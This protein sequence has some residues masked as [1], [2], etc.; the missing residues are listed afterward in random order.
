[1]TPV[2][3]Q[4]NHFK[5]VVQ[6]R[7]RYR[8]IPTPI[9][10]DIQS[11]TPDSPRWRVARCPTRC[12]VCSSKES[13]PMERQ[14]PKCGSLFSL[15]ESNRYQRAGYPLGP[16]NAPSPQTQR[17]KKPLAGL[18]KHF[19]FSFLV[20]T[21]R[22]APFPFGKCREGVVANP[23]FSRSLLYVLGTFLLLLAF[24]NPSRAQ[25]IT[26]DGSLPTPTAVNQVGTTW[27][28]SGG[29]RPGGQNGTTLYHSFGNFSVPANNTAMFLNNPAAPTTNNILGRVTGG[30]VSSIMG[31]IDTT[32][33]FP[34]ASLFLMNTAGFIFGPNATLNVGGAFTA[35]N[36]NNIEMDDVNGTLFNAVPNAAADQL[37]VTASVEAFGFLGDA[38][39]GIVAGS[40]AAIEVQGLNTQGSKVTLVGRDAIAGAGGPKVEGVE[41]NGTINSQGGDVILASLDS[42]GKALPGSISFEDVSQQGQTTISANIETAGGKI[43][44]EGGQIIITGNLISDGGE[45]LI[46]EDALAGTQADISGAITTGGGNVSIAQEATTGIQT[47]LT[48]DVDTGGG[49]FV[50]AENA[51][52][53]GQTDIAST[54]MTSGGEVKIDENV[55]TGGEFTISGTATTVGG[56]VTIGNENT[57]VGQVTIKENGSIDTS[58]S[59]LPPLPPFP[60]PQPGSADGGKVVIRGEVL[61]IDENSEIKTEPRRGLPFAPSPGKGGP[62]DIRAGT[63][64]SM[65]DSEINSSALF[66]SD[67]GSVSIIGPTVKLEN[68]AINATAGNAPAGGSGSGGNVEIA[69]SAAATLSVKNSDIETG[70]IGG[71]TGNGGSVTLNGPKVVLEDGFIDAGS[72]SNTGRGGRVE[73]NVG[74][75]TL[76]NYVVRSSTAGG[77]QAGSFIVQ[78]EGGDGTLAKTVFIQADSVVRT[79]SNNTTAQ[80]GGGMIGVFA[81][82]VSLLSGGTLDARSVSGVAGQVHVTGAEGVTISGKSSTGVVSSTTVQRLFGGT[83]GTTSPAVTIDTQ[84]FT[85]SG[86]GRITLTNSGEGPGGN[87]ILQGAGGGGTLAEAVTVSGQDNL[88]NPS[89][90]FSTTDGM[91]PGGN[92]ILNAVQAT[93]ANGATVTASS[94]SANAGAGTAG[95]VTIETSGSIKVDQATVASEAVQGNGGDVN[96]LA[97]KD[98][99]VTK[100]ST[101]TAKSTNGR[102]GDINAEAGDSIRVFD[103]ELLTVS[104]TGNGGDIDL[105]AGNG[106]FVDPSLISTSVGAGIGGNITMDADNIVIQLSQILAQAQGGQGG[107]ITLTANVVLVDPF[108]TI[109]ASGGLGGLP[110]VVDIQAPI[111]NLNGVIAPLSEQ[112]INPASL[113]AQRCAAQKGGQFSSFVNGGRDGSPPAPGGFLPSPLVFSQHAGVKA[114][115]GKID[116][117]NFTIVRLGFVNFINPRGLEK[118]KLMAGI[119]LKFGCA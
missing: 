52:V 13:N 95:T 2:H 102:A 67:A 37:L 46:A 62:V 5:E 81:Q 114:G 108:S 77:L 29:H 48:G 103:S 57:L 31:T 23:K 96:L 72:S 16:V 100:Q 106:I 75:L 6:A 97:G 92:A 26:S 73:F 71:T 93:V 42:P 68:S 14:T 18:A 65:V 7:D 3:Y 35:T 113:F 89:G 11:E 38:T 56:N 80:A 83:A 55:T 60:P 79:T 36:A 63:S 40:K 1:M 9:Y 34:G 10:L 94:T 43:E 88:G 85:L 101:I 15:W 12:G 19:L 50:I 104:G 84:N 78:G 32:T 47:N 99:E 118:G 51:Q 119:G 98:V 74:D 87:F 59:S 110:G 39:P 111:Q 64:F 27:N 4:Q 107:N 25:S 66:A 20:T 8:Y 21:K 54:V 28:I 61:N 49:D 53:G 90:I 58:Q 76:T 22:T 45:V 86:G 69:T 24:A 33:N 41:V 70:V 116:Y 112:I 82:E 105:T 30:N 117:S 115:Q 44:I 17:I 91:G 109:S